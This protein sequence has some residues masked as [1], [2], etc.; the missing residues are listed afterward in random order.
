LFLILTTADTEIQAL[1]AAL[2]LLPEGFPPVHAR[3][4]NELLSPE[5]LER[6]V[7]DDLPGARALIV[8]VLG[9]RPY[10]A[11]GFER[12]A[13]E[14]RDRGIAFLALPG[15]QALDPELTALC[16]APLPLVT[17]V[18][19]YFTQGG[20]FN[21]AQMLRCLSDNLLLT[22]HGYDP[23]TPLPRDGLY[24][25][26]APDGLNLTLHEWRSRFARPDRPTVGI[27]FYRAHWMANNLAP[28]EALI[29][30][31]EELG[32]NALAVFCYSL[33]DDPEQAGGVPAV[34]GQFLSDGQGRPTVDV[35]ISTLSFT[36]AHLSEGTHVEASGAVCDLLGRLDVPVLQAVLCTSS[37][38]EWEASP[39]GLT[40]R[41]TAM[42]VVLPE[43]DGR[44]NTVAISFKE[45]VWF[46]ARIGTEI[47]PYVPRPDRV[48]FVA[49]LALNFARL[50]R[51]PAA[52][53]K[54]A[55]LFGNYPTKN[56]RIG[57]GVGLDTP[58]SVMNLLRA[59][60]DAGYDVGEEL[61]ADGDALMHALIDGCTND[62]EFL[63][64]AQLRGAAGHVSL[65]T[66]DAW[67]NDLPEPARRAMV[68][69]WGVPLG[70]VGR[71][72][73]TLAIP[74]LV[75]G[76][77]FVGIQPPR[78][79]GADPMA[80]YHSPDLPPTHHY[81][82]YYRWLRDE[83]G[84]HA[85]LH[86]GKH[87]N[88]EWLPGKATALSA[89]CYPEIMLADLPNFYP[90]IINNPGEGTQAKRRAHAVIVDHLIPPMTQAETYDDLARLEQWLDEYYR[91]ASL[92]PIKLPF[93]T[94]QI[95]SLVTK[96]NLDRDLK[97]ERCPE[98]GEFDAFLQEID[99]YLCELGDAQIRDGLHILGEPPQDSQRDQLIRA[100][101]RLP[102]GEIPSL[103]DSV[104]RALG[105]DPETLRGDLGLPVAEGE[106]SE[107][108]R[109]HRDY[110]EG[111]GIYA[112][113]APRRIG[114]PEIRINPDGTQDLTPHRR[115]LEPAGEVPGLLTRGDVL[116]I[117][118][119]EAALLVSLATGEQ[120]PREGAA[121][122]R[123][124]ELARCLDFVRDE[125]VPRLDRTT[126]ELT[127]TLRGLSGRFVPAGPSGAPTRGMARILP[128]GRNFYSIDIHT[129]PTETA[130]KVGTQAAERLIAKYREEHGGEYPRSVGIVVWGT[131]TMRTHGDDIAEIL[132]LM[133]VRPAWV[134]ESRRLKG[135]ELVPA[136]ELGRPR[137]DVTVRI[138]GFFRDAFPNVV[139]LLDRAVELVAAAEEDEE[140]NY[141]RRHVRREEQAL[142]GQGVAPE[143][144]ARQARYR[145]F[146]S[147]PGSY[148]A[149]LLNLI[150]ERNWKT[151]ADLAEVYINWGS[152][153]YTAADH[154]VAAP[155]P[156]RR[157]L[158]QVAVAVQN[159]D[160]RE[161]DIFDSDDYFQFH[162]G[163]I[164]A[165]RALT[166]ENPAA[167]F[168]DTANP[169]NVRVRDLAD[170]ARRV[171][172]SRVVNPKWIASVMRHGY[173][174]AFEMAATVDYLF[175]Y[176]A[177]A[178]VIDDWMFEDLSRA[179]LL[180]PKVQDFLQEKNPWALRSMAERLLEA[181]DRGLWERPAPET[182]EALREIYLRNESLLESR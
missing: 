16:H 111:R 98:A 63:T 21:F 160:N 1:A 181:A 34:F 30:Q 32:G 75:F 78:G 157:R 94:Q 22:G 76:N 90:Y 182:V 72:D 154:G 175:G 147:K 52:S 108:L 71:I 172:R 5:A 51:T 138:S 136:A 25:P 171:F 66:Y 104:A 156:F 84:A 159:Q 122:Q 152:Y 18:L 112:H 177:T 140:T 45:V 101:M 119:Q 155:G 49:R 11:D 143:T 37:S 74:G 87:G 68:A 10:F 103:R 176:E 61:P 99:G 97:V 109:A 46:D 79:F 35:L 40:P 29:R 65:A 161:H 100:M 126:D 41:D 56:A 142:L 106:M 117:V 48:D 92:D 19:E 62:E 137:I 116:E 123:L 163:M 31:V 59:L 105:V 47:R 28:I 20:F 113:G 169:D 3:H 170:E 9:G 133:G 165:I 150:D 7:R 132:H 141:L 4:A 43:F 12:L 95:W 81:L 93:I 85:V 2:R 73:D 55:I 36:V 67:F 42:N 148:G 134:P 130:W 82:A 127:N 110:R 64:D 44:I 124:P 128:T 57:N 162:G 139:A 178:R 24:H 115:L 173:K 23:P 131:S 54:V 27:L 151:D 180:D 13:R 69:Q 83:F 120:D 146:G 118:D 88:L 86:M 6:F 33:K 144:A 77:V 174:G 129:I 135:V 8:R 168:G 114:D 26:E 60:R 125:L 167:Y 179:Y 149:G 58:A 158:S 153:A 166:G 89:G 38:A 145:V 80:I 14:C 121:R 107:R 96:N 102:N 17:Q 39:A 164:A 15:E 50:R 53:K 91:M 70:E